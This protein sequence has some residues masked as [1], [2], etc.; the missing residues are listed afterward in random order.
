MRI[1]FLVNHLNGTDGWSR[2]SLD[3]VK[4]IKNLG[5]QVLCLTSKKSNE[6]DIKQSPLLKEPLKY[7]RYPLLSFW[8]AIW[9]NKAIKKFKP[10]II[11]FLVE[12]YVIILPFLKTKRAKIF[13]TVHGTYSVIPILFKNPLKKE[14]FWFWSKIYYRKLNGIIAVSNYTRNHILKFFSN[15]DSKIKVITNGINLLEHK[16]DFREKS[17]NEVKRILFVGAIKP[18]KGVLE[19]I[20]ACRYYRDNFLGN[21]IYEI[22]GKYSQTDGY[23]Q[24]LKKKINDYNLSDKIFFKGEVSKEDLE[25]YYKKADLFLM[26]SLNIE[27]NFEGFG[28]VFLEAN[29]KGVPCIGSKN[30]GAQEAILNGK[31]G[32]VVNPYDPKEIATK[33]D[34]ILN[35]KTIDSQ[36]CIQWAKENDIKLKIREILDFYQKL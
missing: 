5:H 19:A 24:K 36:D 16:I 21:F 6:I 1:L 23:Y 8:S 10:D 27:N 22:I 25:R 17:K 30:C 28:L 9:I 34:L 14:I 29:A 20:E 18:R 2:Y 7:L 15:L 4:G 12:P 33:M 3:L 26:P 11:H 35:K 13:L 32:Y 31:T